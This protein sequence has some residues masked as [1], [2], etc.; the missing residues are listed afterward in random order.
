M[1]SIQTSIKES[2]RVKQAILSDAALLSLI[3]TL[4][5]RIATIYRRGHKL[6][7]AGNGGSAADAQH[8]AGELVNRFCFDRPALAALAL[9]TDTSVLTSIGNDSSFDQIFA[10]QVQ[11]LGRSGDMFIGIS[12]SG[13]S[14][15]MIEALRECSRRGIVSVGLTG[16]GGG[17]MKAHCDYCIQVPSQATPRVQESQIMIAHILCGLVEQKIFKKTK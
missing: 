8:I 14:R 17:K 13:N 5:R 11:A 15:N 10:R 6:L 7:L 12:T 2:I 3:D 1:Q 16:Q 4:A 9:T